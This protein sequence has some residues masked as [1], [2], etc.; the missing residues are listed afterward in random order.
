VE[1]SDLRERLGL[2][3][4]QL[5]DDAT[6]EQ[7]MAAFA[8]EPPESRQT[9]TTPPEATPPASTPA[10]G[11]GDDPAGSRETSTPEEVAAAAATARTP[12]NVPEGMI[13]IDPAVFASMEQRM[14]RQDRIEARF[15]EQDRD[16]LL[17]EAVEAGKFPPARKPHYEKMYDAD[18]EGTKALIASMAP[19]MIPVAER[20]G[21]GGEIDTFSDEDAYPAEWLPE[22]NDKNRQV[23]VGRD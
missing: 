21:A 19:N 16:I 11:G 20:G 18:V 5:P 2:T 8:Q 15:H 4:E 13:V 10:A 3:A 1:L 12:R 6:P 7:I 9:P 22:V 23:T 17:K 14:K